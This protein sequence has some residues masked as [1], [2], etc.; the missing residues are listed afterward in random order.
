MGARLNDWNGFDIKHPP[1][2]SYERKEQRKRFGD[3]KQNSQEL[4]KKFESANLP[5]EG[6]I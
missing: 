5:K 2:I 1:E 3:A 4:E 6:I